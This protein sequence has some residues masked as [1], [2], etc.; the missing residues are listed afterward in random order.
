M[1]IRSRLASFPSQTLV[2]APAT[3]GTTDEEGTVDVDTSNIANLLVDGT[4]FDLN[5]PNIEAVVFYIDWSESWGS[6]R[7]H[8]LRVE[9]YQGLDGNGNHVSD[10]LVLELGGDPLPNITTANE[11]HNFANT[12]AYIT[13]QGFSALFPP[14]Q[15]IL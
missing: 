5:G 15:S 13:G 14:N 7:T 10:N 12:N 8:I 4:P 3:L 2:F 11:F 6:Y 9:Q 1:N